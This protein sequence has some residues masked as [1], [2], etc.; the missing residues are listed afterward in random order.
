VIPLARDAG[1]LDTVSPREEI[2]RTCRLL[3][4]PGDV[5]EVRVLKAGRAGTVS[6]YFDDHEAL[7]DAVLGYDG[8]VP[9]IYITL[10]P[11]NPALFARAANRLQP[12]AQITTSDCDILKRQCLLM[13]FDP[14]RPTGISS[15]NHQHGRAISVACAAWDDLRGAGFP[16]PVVGD[17]GNGAHLLY[18]L[19]MPNDCS[20]TE[21]VKGLLAGIAAH[22]GTEDINVDQTVFNAGRI[23]KLYGTRTCKGDNLPERPHRRSRLL[24]IPARWTVLEFP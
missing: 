7:A 10:N 16:D 13:D 14:V 21:L 15:T 12:N 20:V 3:M 18:R 6:G 8:K 9:G 5:H 1:I 2:L 11:V 4:A 19:D 17:S 22:C 23:V 24:E